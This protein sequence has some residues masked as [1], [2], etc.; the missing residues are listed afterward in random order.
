MLVNSLRVFWSRIF[1]LGLRAARECP[2]AFESH[3]SE[4]PHFRVVTCGHDI[5]LRSLSLSCIPP[6]DIKSEME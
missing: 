1:G 4:M 2:T 5:S 6:S 3:C